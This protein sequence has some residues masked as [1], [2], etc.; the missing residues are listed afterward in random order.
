V[1]IGKKSW[2]SYASHRSPAI[3]QHLPKI[4]KGVLSPLD[5]LGRRH[6]DD[7]T[8]QRL[9]FLYAKD[10]DVWRDLEVV[11]KGWRELGRQAAID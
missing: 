8:I 10:Y 7:A 9:N 3:G 5:A 11:W 2:V 4:R 1:I 6:L